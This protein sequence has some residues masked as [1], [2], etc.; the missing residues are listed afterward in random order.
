MENWGSN[1]LK[2]VSFTKNKYL[3]LVHMGSQVPL[4]LASPNMEAKFQVLSL[5]KPLS[6]DYIQ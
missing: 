4:M 6:I 3:G 5:K 1:T 2:W